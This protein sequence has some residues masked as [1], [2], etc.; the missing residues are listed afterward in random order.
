ME[1]TVRIQGF[2]IPSAG[3]FPIN[4]LHQKIIEPY[5][6]DRKSAATKA[7]TGSGAA[8]GVALCVSL[9]WML[10]SA[11][12]A[13]A[14]LCPAPEFVYQPTSP[15][16]FDPTA[17]V[18]ASADS[19]ETNGNIV[20]L[21]GATEIIYQNRKLTAE[22]ARY[23]R[24]EGNVEIDGNLTYESDGVQLKSNDATIDISA[25]TFSMGDSKYEVD[26][27]DKR[28]TGQASSMSRTDEGLFRL[29]NATYSTCPPG[30]KS[31][32]IEASSIEL[33]TEEGIG[34]AK[35][36]R[37]NFKGVPLLAV[38]RF[39]FPISQKRKTGFLA[40][41]LASNESTGFEI[42]VPYY[43]NIRPNLDATFTPRYMTRKGVQMQAEL[44]YLNT[45]GSWILDSEYLYDSDLP[46]ADRDRRF[47]HLGHQ[48]TFL[49]NW[50]T[51]LEAS[52]VSDKDYFED[53]GDSLSIASI[54]HLER[55]ADL[56]YK[57][58][59][60]TFLSRLQS[61]QTVDE[62]IVADER[63]YR[64]LPQ[65]LF[66]ADWPRFNWG[67]ESRLD[68]ELVYFDRDESVTGVRFDIEPRL[69]FPINRDAWFF[70][71]TITARHTTY[72]LSDVVNN[73]PTSIN[74]TLATASIDT[75]LFFDRPTADDGSLQTL[76]PRLFFLRVPFRDQ[77]NIPVFDSSELDFNISQLFRENRFS[78]ADRVADAN[79]V[80]AALTTRFIDG[81]TGREYLRGSIGQIFYFDDRR[82]NLIG[83]EAVNTR[84]TSDFVAE[85]AAEL[86]SNWLVRS[87]IQFNP[88]DRNT[89]RSSA[90]LS[91]QPDADHILNFGHRN[92]DTGSSAETE[93]LDFSFVW[94]VQDQW[95]VAGRWN[96]SLDSNSS[97]ETMIGLEYESCCWA[98]RFA[99]RRFVSDDGFDHD[100]S[101]YFQ[102]V[103]KGL[104]PLGDNVGELLG[105]G[106]LGYQDKY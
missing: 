5:T 72:S 40:P 17:P 106:V 58:D 44:R 48:G 34:T 85:I 83:D 24:D 38:P 86:D 59:S 10:D 35:D 36:I 97:L 46:V 13:Y 71:P 21:K 53:L 100:T 62:A 79:Q 102:L 81:P 50:T 91:F 6:P 12:P 52:S 14:D 9:C 98:F 70:H 20:T 1:K 103:L 11:T 73:D 51:A 33:D 66:N 84:D 18:E 64:R 41:V 28:A 104:A 22:N 19:V 88:D 7:C 76:E 93:Q 87:S 75:G 26:L 96:Y 56:L 90:L 27:G 78:G 65:F 2:P 92:V 68:S 45:Q 61:F 67:G 29:K 25:N 49:E 95:R 39:S 23:N 89:V 42:H 63:P 54:T 43:W 99:A 69:S 16:A 47:V 82:V 3:S 31:W 37:L 32:F 57:D 55:R 101:Y 60:Y 77:N 80:S 4:R 105:A 94:P 30:D 74:R 8:A 15:I